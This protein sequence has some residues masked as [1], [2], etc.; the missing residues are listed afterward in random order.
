MRTAELRLLRPKEKAVRAAFVLQMLDKP[1][2]DCSTS[3]LRKDRH[4]LVGVVRALAAV[5]VAVVAMGPA[6][7][8][9][10]SEDERKLCRDS[11]E[12]AS[13]VSRD[14]VTAP[15][16][17]PLYQSYCDALLKI[18]TR[19]IDMLRSRHCPQAD[20]AADRA[21]ATMFRIAIPANRLGRN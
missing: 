12:I 15:T 9:D 3:S 17:M 13:R 11:A 5:I 18:L 10:L 16:T 2:V 8:D 6:R 20:A 1:P 14:L 4:D 21:A 19:E 7:A